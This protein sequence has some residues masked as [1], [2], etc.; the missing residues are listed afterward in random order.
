MKMSKDYDL[1]MDFYKLPFGYTSYKFDSFNLTSENHVGDI[2]LR[3]KGVKIEI[4]EM[5]DDTFESL[6]E[7]II[8][9][10]QKLKQHRF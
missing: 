6:V 8:I 7:K 4:K 1:S 9:E 2:T 10:E 5:K 3:R